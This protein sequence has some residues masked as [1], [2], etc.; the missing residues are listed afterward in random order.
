MVRPRGGK[1][2]ASHEVWAMDGRDYYRE[3][4]IVDIFR[5]QHSLTT[6]PRKPEARAEREVDDAQEGDVESLESGQN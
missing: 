2:L 3:H 4:P 1:R 5:R 6:F